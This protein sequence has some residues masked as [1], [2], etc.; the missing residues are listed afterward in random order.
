MATLP[1]VI[2][3]ALMVQMNREIV[4]KLVYKQMRH[5][6]RLLGWHGFHKFFHEQEEEEDGHSTRFAKFMDERGVR[7]ILSNVTLPSIPLSETPKDYFDK[8]LALEKQYTEYINDIYK[9]AEDE[10]D[11]D[12]C[13][14]LDWFVKEQHDSV[15]EFT[16]IVKMFERAGNDNAALLE[17]DEKLK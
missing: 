3:D 11:Y 16:K 12:T 7:P 15:D 1:K 9:T 17:L 2:Q 10:D 4:A 5:D 8:A 14:F 6:M 13:Y